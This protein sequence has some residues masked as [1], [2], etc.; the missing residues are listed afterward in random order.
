MSAEITEEARMNQSGV[1]CFDWYP[2]STFFHSELSFFDTVR[3]II[4]VHFAL[5]M[6]VVGLISNTLAYYVLSKELKPS[7]TLFLLK[8]LS[9]IDSSVLVAILIW[10]PGN[11]IYRFTGHL[12]I[13]AIHFF[14]PC[15]SYLWSSV[16]ICKNIS[17][18]GIVVVIAERYVAVCKPHRAKSLCTVGRA[19][20]VV[21]EKR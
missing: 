20:K 3:F 14:I 17:I 6:I 15:E 19:K 2:W 21:L 4:G 18:Y 16:W 13:L 7:S 5:F 12:E 1:E 10:Q 8:F 9:V 11:N